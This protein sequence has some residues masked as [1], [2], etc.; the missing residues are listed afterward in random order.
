M[1]ASF[2]IFSAP[3][4]Q[5]SINAALKSSQFYI[6]MDVIDRC[7]SRRQQYKGF[8]EKNVLYV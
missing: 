6:L 1:S 4:G 3:S 5:T 7:V 2:D 8:V